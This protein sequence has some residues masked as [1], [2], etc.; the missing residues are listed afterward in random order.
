MISSEKELNL[1][2][3]QLE[4]DIENDITF[5]SLSG[6]YLGDAEVKSGTTPNGKKQVTLYLY[7]D[8]K[9][10]A[11]LKKSSENMENETN[12]LSTQ[13]KEALNNDSLR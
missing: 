7:E 11:T 9:L 10:N 2:I 3:N 12:I 8:G 5:N 13:L 6:I 1:K 4:E